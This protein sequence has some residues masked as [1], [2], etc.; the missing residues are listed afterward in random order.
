MVFRHSGNL[1]KEEDGS[2]DD[3]LYDWHYLGEYL[4][5]PIMS[6]SIHS[7]TIDIIIPQSTLLFVLSFLKKFQFFF[8]HLSRIELPFLVIQ[9]PTLDDRCIAGTGFLV[10]GF[11][12]G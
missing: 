7:R 9:R 4:Q 11:Y 3:L 8:V 10:Q 6:V 1:R 2:V 5:T 12:V